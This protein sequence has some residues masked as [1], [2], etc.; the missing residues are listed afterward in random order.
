MTM[1]SALRKNSKFLRKV[2]SRSQSWAGY[3][4]ITN[5]SDENQDHDDP[6]EQNVEEKLPS[7]N[8]NR[9]HDDDDDLGDLTE[10]DNQ[11]WGFLLENSNDDK[12]EAEYIA[13]EEY[14]AKMTHTKISVD[15]YLNKKHESERGSVYL[16]SP[17]MK[18]KL[19]LPKVE[20]VKSNSEIKNWLAF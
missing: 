2:G 15:V 14:S 11:V 16:I 6:G 3:S 20:L 9:D 12:Y 17:Q 18:Q 7:S 8:E 5:I 13:V 19:K 1:F 10:L 4:I